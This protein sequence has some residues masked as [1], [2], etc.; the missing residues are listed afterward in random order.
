MDRLPRSRRL[1]AFSRIG[2]GS[3]FVAF[4]CATL[5][6]AIAQPVS[7]QLLHHD[8]LVELASLNA[9]QTSGVK[10][11]AAM[12]SVLAR[13]AWPYVSAEAY[14]VLVNASA[15]DEGNASASQ[16]GARSELQLPTLSFAPLEIVGSQTRF[17]ALE[18][19]R[20]SQTTLIGRQHIRRDNAGLFVGG[21]RASVSREIETARASNLETGVWGTRNS[22]TAGV[23]V[24]RT[25]TTDW[26]LM[27]AAGYF[28]T[29]PARA[30]QVDDLNFEVRAQ[31]TRVHAYVLQSWRRGVGATSGS[32]RATTGGATWHVFSH[33][34]LSG[35]LGSQQA[36]ILRGLPAAQIRTLSLRW[37]LAPW[38]AQYSAPVRDRVRTSLSGGDALAREAALE[39]TENGSYL[40]LRVA[41]AADAVVEVAGSFN[42]WRALPLVYDGARFTVRL[43]LASGS[44]RFALRVNGGD[45]RAVTGFARVDDGLGGANSLVVVP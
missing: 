1:A 33:W 3:S 15:Q 16:F 11:S 2:R 44:H 7:A 17:G 39:Q 4:G 41:A 8:V 25:L 27:E 43:P 38:R 20:G 12:A 36:D 45:W 29:T 19:G 30:Y 37:Q 5:L 28:L 40:V 9:R 35:T 21:G 13:A 18:N 22:V 6:S 42:E 26:Q 14:A 34:S 23:T 10:A 31:R 24:Q 32:S